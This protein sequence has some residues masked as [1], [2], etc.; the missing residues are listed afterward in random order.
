MA[1]LGCNLT[2]SGTGS[3]DWEQSKPPLGK[4]TFVPFPQGRL[5]P[6]WGCLDLCLPYSLMAASKLLPRL[7]CPPNL[8]GTGPAYREHASAVQGRSN[9][10]CQ[11]CWHGHALQRTCFMATGLG[12][13]VS[14]RQGLDWALSDFCEVLLMLLKLFFLFCWVVWAMVS[15][16]VLEALRMCLSGWLLPVAI[17]PSFRICQEMTLYHNVGSLPGTF[18][19]GENGRSILCAVW[20][21]YPNGMSKEL[22]KLLLIG[23]EKVV[24]KNQITTTLAKA[25]RNVAHE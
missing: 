3:I 25:V 18:W 23:L 10:L 7:L 9:C 5:Q 15:L 16:A 13:C 19:K 4:G 17:F 24:L 12:Q 22:L 14:Q 6:L 8:T 20:P 2:C 11:K 21:I 1:S